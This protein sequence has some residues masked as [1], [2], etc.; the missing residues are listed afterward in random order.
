MIHSKLIHLLVG[1]V[2]SL[3]PFYAQSENAQP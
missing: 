2:L 3:T 1:V